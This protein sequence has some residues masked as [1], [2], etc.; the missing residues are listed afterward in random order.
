MT[1]SR[2]ILA[3]ASKYRVALLSQ[4]GVSFEA[5]AHRVDEST[6]A[7]DLSRS[8][9]EVAQALAVEKAQSLARAYPDAFILGSDQVAA[10]GRMRLGKPGT[11][12]A[13]KAQLKTLQGSTHQLHTGVALIGPDGHLEESCI[14]CQMHMRPLDDDEIARYV[15]AD[16]PVDCAGAYKIEQMGPALF[17]SHE[18]PDYTAIVGLPLMTVARM[19]R[20]AGFRIP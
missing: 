10:H 11:L 7:A 6:A 9:E 2:L 4:L 16:N 20:A 17:E 13:A 19:L 3:S 8:A 15:E 12:E 1:Q 5:V 14:T 18:V